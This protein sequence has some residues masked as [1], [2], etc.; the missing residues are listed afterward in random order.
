MTITNPP[1]EKIIH[2]TAI[3][4]GSVAALVFSVW[5]VDETLFERM[6]VPVAP[7]TPG[8][9]LAILGLGLVMIGLVAA[10]WQPGYGG[11][12]ILLGSFS[13]IASS[14]IDLGRFNPNGFVSSVF[15]GV[16]LL[17]IIDHFIRANVS[18]QTERIA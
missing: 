14:N 8:G 13:L 4:V 7:L 10:W 2:W 3:Y 17:L 1:V 11:V 15:A 9:V 12:A 16:G 6:S 18:S 5:L